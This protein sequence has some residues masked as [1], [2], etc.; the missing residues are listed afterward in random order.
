[1]AYPFIMLKTMSSEKPQ[2]VDNDAVEADLRLAAIIESSDDAILSTTLSGVILS[3]N[4]GA[5]KIYGYTANEV[6]G[7]SIDLIVPSDRL[8]EVNDILE[9]ISGDE[10]KRSYENIRLTKT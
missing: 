10:S 8:S 2:E 4:K 7:R 6:I 9:S 1:M 5:E 3:W